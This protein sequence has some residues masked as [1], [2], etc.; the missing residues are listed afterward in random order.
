MR[1]DH[2]PLSQKRPLRRVRSSDCLPSKNRRNDLLD[3]DSI[4]SFHSFHTKPTSSRDKNVLWNVFLRTVFFPF[5]RGWWVGKGHNRVSEDHFAQM[6]RLYALHVTI[7]V[8]YLF[9]W[10]PGTTACVGAQPSASPPK[11]QATVDWAVAVVST[12]TA[13]VRR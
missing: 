13:D 9:D 7:F 6:R 3:V 8:M 4:K 5:N 11:P 12:A 10:L 1:T 2:C